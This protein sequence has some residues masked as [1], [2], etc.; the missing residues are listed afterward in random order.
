MK[1]SVGAPPMSLLLFFAR[2]GV[3]EK[4]EVGIILTPTGDDSEMEIIF[5]FVGHS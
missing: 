4:A 3:S 5:L 1:F 2:A